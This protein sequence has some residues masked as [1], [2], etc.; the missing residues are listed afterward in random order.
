MAAVVVTND[1]TRIEDC[2]AYTGWANFGGSGAGGSSEAPFAYQSSNACN[3]KVTAAAGG[4][5]GYTYTSDG[6]SAFTMT[7]GA[8]QRTWMAKV[9]VSDW[10]GLDVTDGVHVAIGSSS[11]AY[12][13]MVLA[14]TDSPAAAFADYGAKGGY[15][16]VPIDPNETA[17]R[18]GGKGSGSP[19][20]AAINF[21]G[22]RGAF[23]SASAKSE[24]V[25]IDALDIG[26][27]LYLVGGDGGTADATWADFVAYDE[28][29]SAN[30]FGYAS[31]GKG[32]ALL[33]FG[34][35]KVG[36]NS[37]GSVATELT[38]DVSILYWL[39]HLAAAGF[40]VASAD[41]GNAST[42]VADGATHIGAGDVTNVDSR[43]DYTVTGTSGTFTFT[44][45]LRNFR[46]LTYTSGCDVGGRIE[47]LD[48]T[49][50][51]AEIQDCIITTTSAAN[52]ATCNDPTFGTTTDLHDTTFIQGGAGHALEISGTTTV[53]LTNLTGLDTTGGYGADTTS[54]AAL[55]FSAG[56]GSITVNLTNTDTPTFRTAGVTVTFVQTFT[57]TLTG[58]P[59]GVQVTIVNSSTRTELQNSTSTGAD[60]T[61]DHSGGEI[62]D[63]MFMANDYDPNVSD[64][65]DLT[66]PTS[67]S[68]LP[69]S[70]IDDPNYAN[71]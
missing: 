51:G 43:P 23:S 27:G 49:Q 16:I 42:I 53:T 28:G 54:S 34:A 52:V 20:L 8:T 12:Y 19:N 26:V 48:L 61:Y 10:G 33:V 18:D 1:N 4:G 36:E 55:Y 69:V 5:I 41:L 2:E 22:V 11:S 30:R 67:S 60:V 37:G 14:G 25:A 56:S 39:D 66:L 58:I 32:G 9:F 29:T 62:V 59:T 15:L 38:D 31:T 46:N 57:L 70:L 24:N 50:G 6:G 40:S 65:Y 63:I 13:M 7:G 71:P 47:C 35:L 3:R 68:S 45:Q 21:F 64:I 44:G 17:Y